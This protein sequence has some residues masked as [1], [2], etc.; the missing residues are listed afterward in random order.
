MTPSLPRWMSTRSQNRAPGRRAINP[1][2]RRSAPAVVQ[3]V[4]RDGC[5]KFRSPGAFA[6]LRQRESPISDDLLCLRACRVTSPCPLPSSAHCWRA[7]PRRSARPA[8]HRSARCSGAGAKH[9]GGPVATPPLPRCRS[10]PPRPRP[11][12][13]ATL[14]PAVIDPLRPDA[15]IDPGRRRGAHGL[16]A[17]ACAAASRCP[18]SIRYPRAQKRAVV[19][20]PG[21]T[22]W[23][24]MT[25]R[26]E[27]LSVP[28]RRG[29]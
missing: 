5:M 28:H 18:T 27:S 9:A 7:A 6:A 1:F 20:D 23:P 19:C 14:T 4:R 3:S 22:T 13:R 21:P 17:R 8:P 29:S 16:V 11:P 24:R 26:S 2:L 25:E 12:R 10:Q 15:R